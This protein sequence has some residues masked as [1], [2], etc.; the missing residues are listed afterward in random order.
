VEGEDMEEEG[1]EGD[2]MD[3]DR[4]V[5]LEVEEDMEESQSRRRLRREGGRRSETFL[6]IPVRVSLSFSRYGSELGSSFP[7]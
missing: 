5:H 1:E 3:R 4:E 6:R 7:L 2:R